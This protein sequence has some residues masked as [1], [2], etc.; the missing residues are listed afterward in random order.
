MPRVPVHDLHSAPDASRDLLVALKDRY[1]KV[2]NIHGE[3]AHAPVVLAAYSGIQ[4][5]IAEHGSFDPRTSEA[6]AL[7][8]AAADCGYCQAAHTAAAQRAGMNLDETVAARLGR[9]IE[10]KLDALLAVVRAAVTHV[11]QVD[12][13]TW[14][15]A[16]AAG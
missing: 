6:T 13:A 14:R 11:G 15:Q 7:A 16:L 5:A 9:P 1:G 4:A 10:P 8:V 3:M 12:E 2:L